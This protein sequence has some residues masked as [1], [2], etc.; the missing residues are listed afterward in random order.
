MRKAKFRT[1]LNAMHLNPIQRVFRAMTAG[2]L[3][4]LLPAWNVPELKNW[5][6]E[7]KIPGV[8]D[9]EDSDDSGVG[10]EKKPYLV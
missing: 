5:Q 3:K 4:M 1:D 9:S 2:V 7:I 6:N 8:A 10:D